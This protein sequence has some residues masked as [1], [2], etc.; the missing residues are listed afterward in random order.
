L[1][2]PESWKTFGAK[3]KISRVVGKKEKKKKK[4]NVGE[5]F[6]NHQKKKKKSK[7]GGANPPHFSY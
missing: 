1:S 6:G 5:R 2:S 3:Q 4:V 7:A